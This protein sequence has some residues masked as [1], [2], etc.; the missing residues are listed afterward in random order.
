MSSADSR[1]V[2]VREVTGKAMMDEFIRV[3]WSIYR[4]DP[5][6]VPPLLLE[7]REAFS[8]K[9]PFFQHAE[10]K[11]WIACRDGKAVGR[12]SAQIDRLFL[13]LHD[14]ATGF[15]GLIEAPDD[16]AI[17]AALFSSAEN[18]LKAKGMKRVLGPFNLGINQE[19]GLLVE[20]FDTPPYIMMGHALPYYGRLIESLGYTPDQDTLAYEVHANQFGMPENMRKLLE[21]QG[22]RITERAFNRKKRHDDFET[23]RSI[24]NDAWSRNWG[25]VP[26]TEEEFQAVGKELLMLLPDDF[27]RIAEVD[28]Q[29]AAFIA[30]LPNINEV[31]GDLDGRLLPFGWAKLLWRLKVRSVKSARIALMGVRREY[32]RTR[33]G[34]ALAFLTMTGLEEPASRRGIEHAEMSWIL[35]DNQG[36]RNI[37]EQIGGKITKRYRMYRKELV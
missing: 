24:F 27:I 18:W 34:P 7:R 6:W 2:R 5:N 11:T 17:F 13:E 1:Q 10:W 3:P 33:L 22:H 25:F 16:P 19:I 12:I 14:E 30:M 28:G 29:P 23:M 35:E 20:G 31:I 26:F 36:M 15:F 4:D 37:A 8:A 9:N 21:R 32:Q